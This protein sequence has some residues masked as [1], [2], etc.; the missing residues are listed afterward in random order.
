[1]IITNLGEILNCLGYI[2]LEKKVYNVFGL[3]TLNFQIGATSGQNVYWYVVWH[4]W[5]SLPYLIWFFFLKPLNWKKWK[6]TASILSSSITLI[7]STASGP[8]IDFVGI[9]MK[10]E[11]VSS[12]NQMLCLLVWG[13]SVVTHTHHGNYFVSTHNVLSKFQRYSLDPK[14]LVAQFYCLKNEGFFSPQAWLKELG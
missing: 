3:Y 5:S 1:M 4:F 2:E 10:K 11:M 6:G 8:H 13:C 7:S 14:G 12:Y 9:L